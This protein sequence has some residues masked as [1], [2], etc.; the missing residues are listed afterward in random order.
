MMQVYSSWESWSGFPLMKYFLCQWL[1]LI[2]DCRCDHLLLLTASF[3]FYLCHR[4]VVSTPTLELPS[5][6]WCSS[7][8]C[9]TSTVSIWS[10]NLPSRHSHPST[11]KTWISMLCVRF[12]NCC[13]VRYNIYM[14]WKMQLETESSPRRLISISSSKTPDNIFLWDQGTFLCPLDSLDSSP[15]SIFLLI[16][17]PN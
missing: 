1:E 17:A 13:L 14:A 7:I 4:F 12:Q 5:R 8:F 16:C 9:W 10:Y 2:A 15:T 3:S 6:T 11:T